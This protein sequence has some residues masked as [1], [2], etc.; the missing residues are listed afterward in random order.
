M[1]IE[2][3]LREPGLTAA[4]RRELEAMRRRGLEGKLTAEEF[5]ALRRRGRSEGSTL[6]RLLARVRGVRREAGRTREVPPAALAGLDATTRALETAI[7]ATRRVAR[8]EAFGV[9]AVMLA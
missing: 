9:P 3:R 8:M 7:A 2:R 6:R 4:M 1:W 5:R